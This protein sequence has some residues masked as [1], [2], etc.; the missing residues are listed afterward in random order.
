MFQ[1]HFATSISAQNHFK[2]QQYH[3]KIPK[4]FRDPLTIKSSPNE[5]H[6]DATSEPPHN[7]LDI[8]S[9]KPQQRHKTTD[10]S[11]QTPQ[12]RVTSTPK[13]LI[14]TLKPPTTTSKL[15]Y[16]QDIEDHHTTISAPSQN[17]LTI[18]KSPLPRHLKINSL[19]SEHL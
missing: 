12:N 17:H 15:Y 19:P 13:H 7:V 3:L 14:T 9:P 18:S 1:N 4:H 11:T 8:T 6:L 2:K 10:R 16:H 5:K